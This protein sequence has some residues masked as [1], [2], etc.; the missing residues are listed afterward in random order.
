MK[1]WAYKRQPFRLDEESLYISILGNL[2]VYARDG[3][4]VS[5]S[6]LDGFI[7]R[8]CRCDDQK[9]IQIFGFGVNW[10]KN[11]NY[12]RRRST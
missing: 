8:Y 2:F 11:G 9:Y 7:F 3:Y 12:Q 1:F 4:V 10:C 5:S 6:I